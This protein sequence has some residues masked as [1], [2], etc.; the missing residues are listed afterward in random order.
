V[1][2]LPSNNRKK[3]SDDF[4][5]RIESPDPFGLNNDMPGPAKKTFQTTSHTVSSGNPSIKRRRTE[6]IIF[7]LLS[8]TNDL[9]NPFSQY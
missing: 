7:P 8:R 2:S 4:F 3:V 9:S 1:K 5:R 6:P